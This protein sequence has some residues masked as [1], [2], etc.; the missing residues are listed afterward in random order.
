MK[1]YPFAN[2]VGLATIAGA[3]TLFALSC[4]AYP[5]ASDP[6]IRGYRTYETSFESIHDFDGFY[7]VA[8]GDYDSDQEL[9]AEIARSGAYSHKAW[10]LRARADNND[11]IIYLPHRS[12][13]TIQL[14]KTPEGSF[15]TPCLVT[16]W[17][18]VDIDLADRPDGQIDDW[19]SFATLSPDDSDDWRRTVVVNL[20]HDGYLR[21]VH[22]PNQGEQ[23]RL[24][25]VGPENDP[26]G[27]LRFPMREWVRLDVYIDFAAEG[28][29]AKVWQN[30]NLVSYATVNGGRGAMAQAH[31]GLYASAA[32][33]SGTVYNDDLTIR[34]VRDEAEALGYVNR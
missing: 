1:H 20:V 6:E 28:G 2:S 16:L 34:E 19:F 22:V 15:A 7:I 14:Y 13:P 8:K 5:P 30:G 4:V 29:Y 32:L 31:F 26:S 11:G 12:Y 18:Y 9:S 25:Q 17:A 27:D 23:D 33:A 3:F 10:I 21:L 24:Y